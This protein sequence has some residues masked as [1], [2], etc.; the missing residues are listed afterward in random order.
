[1]TKKSILKTKLLEFKNS[2]FLIDL[3]EDDDTGVQYEEVTQS[4]KKG[5]EEV[6]KTNIKK[7]PALLSKLIETLEEFD[8]EIPKQ[9]K[10]SKN[11]TIKEV[12]N[13]R[14]TDSYVSQKDSS[15]IVRR[16]LKGISA[17]DLSL[18]FNQ[19]TEV[20]EQLLRNGNVYVVSKEESKFKARF[21]G[22]RKK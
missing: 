13:V 5:K 22:R 21:W 6:S 9:H 1:L 7:K 10:Q 17:E 19:K 18:Q 20:I 16:Y 2:T 11:K 3:V 15:E 8:D 4:I 14:N 12:D